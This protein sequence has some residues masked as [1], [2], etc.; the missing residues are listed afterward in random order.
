MKTKRPFGVTILAI[1]AAIGA[2]VAIFHTLQMLHLL[3]IN[4]PLGVVKFYT[5]DLLGALLW[6][7]LALIYIWVTRMLWNLDQQGWLFVVILSTLNLILAVVSVFGQSSWEAMMPAIVVNGL[8]LIYGLLP[9]TKEAF[10]VDSGVPEDAA[11]EPVEEE[12][13]VEEPVAEADEAA[14]TE[15]EAEPEAEAEEV[16]DAEVEADADAEDKS[17]A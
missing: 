16:A 3:P 12:A 14:D 13:E 17:D 4:G 10:N 1:L 15:V 5:F 9:G 6:G 2:I 11:P 8:I 7:M